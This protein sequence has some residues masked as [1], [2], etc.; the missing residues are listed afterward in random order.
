MRNFPQRGF[1]LVEGLLSLV[2]IGIAVFGIVLIRNQIIEAMYPITV[3]VNEGGAVEDYLPVPSDEAMADALVFHERLNTA[4]TTATAVYVFGGANDSGPGDDAT[5][6]NPMLETAS[7]LQNWIPVGPNATVYRSAEELAD[8]ELGVASNLES[9]AGAQDFTVMVTEAG[10]VTAIAQVRAFTQS[11]LNDPVNLP[12]LRFFR[13]TLRTDDGSGGEETVSY[14]VYLR[15]PPQGADTWGQDVGATHFWHRHD[16]ASDSWPRVE[17]AGAVVAFPDPLKI[18]AQGDTA[19]TAN[20]SR[21]TY[22][23]PGWL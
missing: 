14:R 12:D 18:A 17:Y 6:P 20:L 2:V 21:L 15:P 8:G 13:A 7:T 4:L 23:L 5:P 22:F 10:D 3:P 16:P 19:Q 1:S 9:T 11:D